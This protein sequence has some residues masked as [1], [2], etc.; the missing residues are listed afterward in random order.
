MLLTS[1]CVHMSSRRGDRSGTDPTIGFPPNTWSVRSSSV[2]I[3]KYVSS[4]GIFVQVSWH[5]SISC[6]SDLNER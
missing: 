4:P 3:S 6:Y 2:F 5:D 1:I